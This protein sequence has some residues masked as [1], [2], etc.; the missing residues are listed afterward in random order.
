MYMY[1]GYNTSVGR[2]CTGGP[3][4]VVITEITRGDDE[5]I[6]PV[7]ATG[8]AWAGTSTTY[9]YVLDNT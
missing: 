4:V 3:Q 8:T 6:A 9:M 2:L 5:P 1:L 7:H